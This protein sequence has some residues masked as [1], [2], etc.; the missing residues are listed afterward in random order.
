[1]NSKLKY[2]PIYWKNGMSFSED[3]LNSQFLAI[4]DKIRD[5][6]AL[7]LTNNNYGLLGG[8]GQLKFSESFRDNINNEKVE[9]SYCRAITQNGSRI[10]ILDQ[11]WE[12]LNKPLSELIGSKNLDTSKF[13]YVLLIVDPFT[14]IPEGIEDEQ[15]SPR[16]KPNTRP[17]YQLELIS[18]NDLKLD[19]LANAIP[20]AKFEITSSGLRKIENYIPPC[21][22]INSHEKLIKKY[23]SYDNYLTALKESSQNIITKIK[24]KRKNKENNALADD[25][26]TLCKKYLEYFVISY[27]EYKLNFKDLPPV[28][29]MWFF[30]KL[31]RVLNHSMDMAYD[32]SHMLKYF[33]QYAADISA[34]EIGKI[35]NNTFET[36]YVHFDIS[37]SLTAVDTFLET[38]HEI[39]KR[40]E[41]LDFRELAPRNIV[42]QDIIS[43]SNNETDRAIRRTPNIKIKRPGNSENLEDE[44]E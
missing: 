9:V 5:A 36:N 35:I 37:T 23:E 33:H 24:H 17:A 16:R 31:A 41:K 13:W 26:D 38:L 1:M 21:S 18:L 6:S 30:A 42:R 25:I 2:L 7:N 34:A 19:N 22:R 43:D 39:F 8:D 32:K 14:R 12:E 15:E 3:H 44:L 20:I 28:K 40:L 27:D 11:T 4:A 10:E 29:L